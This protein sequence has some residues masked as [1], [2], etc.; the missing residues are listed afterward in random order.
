MDKIIMFSNKLKEWNKN[1]F[2]CIFQKKRRIFER[3]Q[4][5]Q[6]SLGEVFRPGLITLDAA[7]QEEYKLIIEQEEI[8]W[9][10][11][12]RNSWHKEGDTNTRFFSSLYYDQMASL[13]HFVMS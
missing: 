7:L 1:T 4:G 8:F 2:G 12:S 10:Q 9:M 13:P 3:L 6:R 11:K 5:I